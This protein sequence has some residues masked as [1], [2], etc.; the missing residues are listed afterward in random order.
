MIGS[1]MMSA[2]HLS[3][4]RRVISQRSFMELIDMKGRGDNPGHRI[5]S[6]LDSASMQSQRIKD[7]RLA[8][9]N[10]V[11]YLGQNCVFGHGYEAELIVE[12]CKAL[13][14]MR[15]IGALVG[16][17]ALRYADAAEKFIVA[18]AKTG[19]IAVVDEATGFQ[20]ERA[21][22]ALA[23]ILERYI[24]KELQPWTK[25]FPEQ[26]YE[27]IFRL[28]KWAWPPTGKFTSRPQIIGKWTDDFIYCRLA[29]GVRDELR[30]KNPS[31]ENG[32]RKHKHHQWL[33]GDVG[34]PKLQSHL[35][36]VIRLMG[37]CGTWGEFKTFLDKFYPRRD[38]TALGFEVE[39]TSKE[40]HERRRPL[41]EHNGTALL[42]I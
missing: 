26:F 6:I 13:L 14:D 5:A 33:T 24:A 2:D 29:P 1:W 37:G 28:R 15:R 39:V 41:I 20:E 35:D 19:I 40:N 12:Y 21:R 8:I 38:K 32:R 4:G 17:V 42:P 25:T 7:L 36:G 10:P 18:L 22:N 9:Q 31:S 27:E 16:S 30:E 11:K 34:N 3:D 23:E